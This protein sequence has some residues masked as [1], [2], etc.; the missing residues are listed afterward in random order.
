MEVNL[1]SFFREIR[2]KITELGAK[3]LIYLLHKDLQALPNCLFLSNFTWL[4]MNKRF[5]DQI[6][7]FKA[8]WLITRHGLDNWINLNSKA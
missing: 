7:P 5:L 6:S 2:H 1:L 8:I 4:Q 3:M